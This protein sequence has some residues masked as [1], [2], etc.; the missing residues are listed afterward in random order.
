MNR[1]EARIQQLQQIPV[2]ALRQ[3]MYDL[4]EDQKTERIL[5]ERFGAILNRKLLHIR[6]AIQRM[7]RDQL[8]SL[9][10]A[11]SEVSDEQVR[12]LF[13]EYRYG[14]NPS[15][16]VYLFDK[17]TLGREALQGFR[18][19]FEEELAAFNATREDGLARLRRVALNHLI[20]LPE[21]PEIIEG[22]HRFQ[23]RLD[24]TDE[25]ETAVST[26]QTQYGF[27]WLSAAEGYAILHGRN[28][29][30]LKALKRAI[31]RGAGVSLTAL[32]ISKQLKNALPFLLRDSFR[33]GRL[34]DPDPGPGRFRW[35]TVAD[36]NPYASGYQELEERYPEVRS[37]RY[38]EIIDEQ[39]ETTLTIRCD[40]GSLSLAGTLKASQLRAWCL[41]RLGQLIGVLNEFRPNAPAYVQTRSLAEVPELAKFNTAQRKCA[42]QIISALLTLKQ[43]P[44]LGYRPVG[45]LPL[46][47]A[48]KMGHWLRSQLPVEYANPEGGSEEGY[49][50]CSVC[51]ATTFHVRHHNDAWKLECREHRRQPWAMTLPLTA[52]SIWQ[53]YLTLDEHDVAA[54]IE[55]LPDDELVQIIAEVVNRYLPGYAFDPK[56][57]SFIVRGPNLI[58][59]PDRSQIHDS[60]KD[61]AKTIIYVTQRIGNVNGGEVVGVRAE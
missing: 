57:E 28:A 58:Y 41:D 13:E 40:R 45:L 17:L 6:Q 14:S 37:A 24:Y 20:S 7:S 49:L 22:S 25:N 50:A 9:V 34:H 26:Y 8:S 23:S 5:R 39:T 60:D 16:Y 42:L 59:Y 48:A 11:C 51:D 1:S 4:V 56:R 27:F 52:E 3:V 33:S 36:E 32:V 47:L 61:E 19:R 44:L 21:R 53:P 43:S 29:E 15:F 38:R 55:L 18:Q 12:Q 35:L 2:F 31:E 54:S 10:D 30:V 46:E